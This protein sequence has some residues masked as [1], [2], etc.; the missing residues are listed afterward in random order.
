[1]AAGVYNTVKGGSTVP[2]KFRVYHLQEYSEDGYWRG[3]VVRSRPG[4]L[5]VI[6]R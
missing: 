5:L 1:M 3:E 2:L 6:R 4:Q